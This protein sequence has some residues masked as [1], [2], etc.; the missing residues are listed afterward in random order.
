MLEAVK[1]NGCGGGESGL[2]S[3]KEILETCMSFCKSLLQPP[4]QTSAPSTPSL[5]TQSADLLGLSM[6]T[7]DQVNTASAQ[8]NAALLVDILENTQN[9]GLSNDTGGL[10]NSFNVDDESFFR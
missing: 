7:T 2:G 6:P 1:L 5:A 9:N 10:G 4:L 3:A 8:N